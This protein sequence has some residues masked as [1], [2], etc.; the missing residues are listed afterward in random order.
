M[1]GLNNQQLKSDQSHCTVAS[2]ADADWPTFTL[3]LFL[4]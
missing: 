4:L 2:D 1:F 3:W